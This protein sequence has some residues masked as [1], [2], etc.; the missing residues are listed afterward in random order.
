MCLNTHYFSQT[1]DY[2]SNTSNLTI[3]NSKF[4][5]YKPIYFNKFKYVGKGFKLIFKRKKNI[6]NCI[7][8]YSHMYWVKLQNTFI[9]KTKKY[10]FLFLTKN[11]QNYNLFVN[12][13]RK[14]KPINRYTLRGVRT[15]THSWIKRKGRKSV[16][17]HV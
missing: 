1:L 13:L 12:I 3:I 16:A 9:K 7:F 11:I 4:K 5:I 10:K 8:G 15:Y 17:T 14:I 6:F 2:F